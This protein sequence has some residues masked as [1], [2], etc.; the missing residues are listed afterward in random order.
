MDC[1]LQGWRGDHGRGVTTSKPLPDRGPHVRYLLFGWLGVLSGMIMG[2]E[3]S[4]NHPQYALIMELVIML[5][6]T[7]AAA[8]FQNRWYKKNQ[9]KTDQDF[10]HTD[11]TISPGETSNVQ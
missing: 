4:T 1:E 3:L 11:R 6:S 5:L 9:P 10:P 8:L 7:L 2:Y